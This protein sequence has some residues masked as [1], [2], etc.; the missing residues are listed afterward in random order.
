MIYRHADGREPAEVLDRVLAQRADGVLA[1]RCQMGGYGGRVRIGKDALTIGV[2]LES[3]VGDAFPGAYYDPRKYA[4]ETLKLL[5]AARKRL[6]EAVELI[7]DVHERLPPSDAVQ[8]AKDVEQ[9]KLFFLED[10]LP[11]EQLDWFERI[12]A[13]CSTP[14]AVGE[15]FNHPLEWQQVIEKRWVDFIRMHVS[16]MGGISPARNVAAQAAAHGI[17]TAWHG[18]ADTSA[19]WQT[20]T[21]SCRHRTSASTSGAVFRSTFTRS[22]RACRARKAACFTRTTRPGWASTSCPSWPPS[23]QP[24]TTSKSG[25]RRGC[26]TARPRC[27]SALAPLGRCQKPSGISPVKQVMVFGAVGADGSAASGASAE[28]RDSPSRLDQSGLMPGRRQCRPLWK[29]PIT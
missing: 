13:V 26:P 25:P 27:R 1:V 11:P 20:C 24:R 28:P 5:E 4:R 16:Q 10:A 29:K 21:S 8:F 6:P 15:L 3:G 14:L 9:F 22:S 12:R 17:R 18:P 2:D 23:I 19:T 7:H